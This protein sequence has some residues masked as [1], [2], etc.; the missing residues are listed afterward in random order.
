MS[1]S[2]SKRARTEEP[3]ES[4]SEDESSIDWTNFENHERSALAATICGHDTDDLDRND[5]GD[6]PLSQIVNVEAVKE[7]VHK[8]AT[9]KRAE[10]KRV[11]DAERAVEATRKATLARKVTDALERFCGPVLNVSVQHHEVKGDHCYDGTE[12]DVA[13]KVS[14]THMKLDKRQWIKFKGQVSVTVELD[15]E[16]MYSYKQETACDNIFPN[17][18]L[19]SRATLAAL[20]EELGVVF[21]VARPAA[22]YLAQ[23]Y[24]IEVANADAQKTS[25]QEE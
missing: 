14:F 8:L 6:M 11:R 25:D 12:V 21:G 19:Q 2:P 20:I 23:Q 18:C 9:E 5:Y 15:G 3:E 22:R 24:G 16:V 1:G 10:Q 7:Y 13:F 4:E 17:G